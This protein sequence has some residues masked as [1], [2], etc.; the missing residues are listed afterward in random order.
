MILPEK[1]AREIN[2]GMKFYVMAVTGGGTSAISNFLD[3]GGASATVIEA[4]IPYSQ[5][6]LDDFLGF[7][8]ETYVSEKT[9]RM[10]AGKAFV[11]CKNYNKGTSIAV[12]I[13]ATAKLMKHEGERHGRDNEIFV[14]IQEDNKTIV[15]HAIFDKENYP[16]RASQELASAQLI[17]LIMY[18]PD[19]SSVPDWYE[20]PVFK[21]KSGYA[22]YDDGEGM[23]VYG[24]WKVVALEYSMGD[25]NIEE[26]NLVIF[27][28][29]F[30]PIH[31]GHIEMAK[32]V[33]EKYGNVD[34][35][36]SVSNVYKPN[37][38][39]IDIN[40]RRNDFFKKKE[41]FMR[42]ILLTN[43]P[44][45]LD[46]MKL[47]PNSVFVMGADAYNAFVDARYYSDEEFV[48]ALNSAS[49]FV[50][51]HRE[52]VELKSLDVAIPKFFHHKFDIIPKEVFCNKISSTEV[53]NAQKD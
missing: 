5:D 4:I 24:D 20:G 13:G 7:S 26:E 12:G 44:R 37:I 52:G 47:F 34:F 29:S 36:I 17:S 39:F 28:G 42:R 8:P 21:K 43:A 27:P 23:V 48:E 50:V 10:M 40:Q 41:P 14:S 2:A 33:A 45:Y 35:E 6:S 9:A 3:F 38:D 15:Y 18:K 25:Y 11:R 32:I 30:N 16:D 19:T 51:F 1:V 46:K 22:N 31:D 53:R 49:K